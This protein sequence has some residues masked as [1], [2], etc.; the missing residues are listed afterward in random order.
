[1]VA[2]IYTSFIALVQEDMK[3]LIAYSSVAHMGFVTLGI[4]SA[5]IQGLHGAVI[6][7][8]SHGLISA[9]LFFCIGSIYNRYHTK[10]I[11]YYGG[12]NSKLPKLSIL[13]LIF[14]LG[15]IGFPGTSGFVGE[16]L[17]LLAAYS[18]NTIVAFISAFGVILAA[19]YMLILYK[20]VFLGVTNENLNI[21][22]NDLSIFELIVYFQ[23]AFLILL[24][25]IK[26]D[27]ILDYTTSSLD[28]ITKL[29]P[30]SI[31]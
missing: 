12:L 20:R 19:S 4:F 31:F 23:L 30:I 21:K 13:F 8:I 16:F 17:T 25:G 11:A 29:Y 18:K 1:V 24:I 26:P 6:Q 9:A 7:M 10:E 15:S 14:T 27:I 22:V 3:K 5:N 28:R 2:I